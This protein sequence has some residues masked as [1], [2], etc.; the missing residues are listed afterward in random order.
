MNIYKIVFSPTG[1]T[2]K[3]ADAVA[4]EI[5]QKNNG[6]IEEVD[7]TDYNMDFSSVAISKDDIA[8]LAVPSYAGRVP[9]V[10]S[11]RISQIKGNGANTVIVCVYGNRD[12]D[13]T[14]I[15]LYDIAKESNF[16]VTSAIAAIAKHS[17]AY[18]YASNRPDE[19]DINK[20]KEFASK[21]INAS[22]LLDEHKLKG[23]RPYKKIGKISVAPKT[24]NN[25]NNCKLCVNKCPVQAI[26]IK[27]PKK[28]DKNKCISCMRCVS[29][30]NYSAK[31]INKVKLD[32][33]HLALKK[34]CSKAK[35]YEFYIN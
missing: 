14:L 1:G 22:E 5:S 18:K 19:N 7:L 20:L 23:N 4:L 17:I 32:L 28:I 30:C 10:A 26:N 11:K 9:A 34:S 29:I 25:C 15:E 8:I 27:N 16:K 3:V 6:S 35:D 31:Y 13:D 24:K 21:I 12:Y 33:I 2:K